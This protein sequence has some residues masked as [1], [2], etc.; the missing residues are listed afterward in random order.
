MR[1]DW[2]APLIVLAGLSSMA[3]AGSSGALRVVPPPADTGDSGD[4]DDTAAGDDTASAGDDTAADDTAAGGDD[5]SADSA[6]SADTADTGDTSEPKYS[7]AQSAGE[8]G[9]FK[10]SAVGGAPVSLGG[11]A[12]LG[13]VVVG[14]R[15]RE[16]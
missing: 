2:L 9:G 5:T 8:E 15:R 13:L 11:I 16:V 3:V 12:L 7:A 4:T 14:R 10:C 6:D 1:R